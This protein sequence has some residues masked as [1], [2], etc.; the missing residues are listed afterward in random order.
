MADPGPITIRTEL[1]PEDPTQIVEFHARVYAQEY[2]FDR[3][4]ADYVAGPLHEFVR[5]PH[6]RQ[7]IWIAERGDELAGCIAI[8]RADPQTAQLR[9]FLVDPACRGAGLGTRLVHE[10]VEFSR[11]AGYAR[12]ILWT[13]SVLT[14]AARLYRAAGFELIEQ[15]AGRRWG[16]D[17]VEEM[18]ALCFPGMPGTSPGDPGSG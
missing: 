3:S 15:R 13:E 18:Y 7:R 17:V 12:I 16:V 6:A 14:A 5:R 1:R 4:F 2:G 8:V 10:A 11:A 9:W